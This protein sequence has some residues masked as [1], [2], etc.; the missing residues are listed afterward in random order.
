MSFTAVAR[1]ADTPFVDLSFEEARSRAEARDKAVFIDFFTTWCGPCK[2]LDAETWPDAR[3]R[4]WLGRRA[5]AIKVDAEE[6]KELARRYGVK[7]YPTLIFIDA[8]T[9]EEIERLVGFLPPE[10]FLEEASIVLE[11]G[12]TEE[13]ISRRKAIAY[14]SGAPA[15]LEYAKLLMRHE[16]YEEALDEMVW[17]YDVGMGRGS[18]FAGSRNTR[19]MDLF[20]ELAEVYEPA[21]EELDRRAIALMRTASRNRASFNELHD[22]SAINRAIGREDRT[23]EL[24]EYIEA[25]APEAEA[26][27]GLYRLNRGD[28]LEAGWY[29]RL[30][31]RFPPREMLVG[32]AARWT[33]AEA[34]I[35]RMPDGD[36]AEARESALR[37]EVSGLAEALE[38]ALG[39]SRAELAEALEARILELG[40][41]DWYARHALA[42][43]YRRATDEASV[44][45][46][47]AERAVELLRADEDAESVSPIVRLARILG[48]A[49]RTGEGLALLRGTLGETA[50]IDLRESLERAIE[51][52][53]GGDQPE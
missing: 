23:R 35:K 39:S 22:L 9:G 40:A 47:H 19:V 7:G 25:R 30:A 8:E 1:A 38:I 42:G 3:V 12:L 34:R 5:V 37:R 16:R 28:L 44:A 49:G 6:E 36:R 53:E 43:A 29:G 18:V 50:D 33:R 4:E 27:S 45:L 11:A 21:R 14:D 46:S 31:E 41:D 20:G 48:D 15:R 52:L 26:L 13:L 24:I 32:S 2:R 17:C 10:R 51:D